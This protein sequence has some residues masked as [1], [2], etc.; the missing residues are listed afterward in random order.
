MQGHCHK[1]CNYD[2]INRLAFR[3]FSQLFIEISRVNVLYSFTTYMKR[4]FP[5]P[6]IQ[7]FNRGVL[8]LLHGTPSKLDVSARKPKHETI[9]WITNR[10]KL[11]M[12]CG[13]LALRPISHITQKTLSFLHSTKEEQKTKTMVTFE[14]CA[15]FLYCI[16]RDLADP[17]RWNGGMTE[18][19]NGMAE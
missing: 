19:R 10:A 5:F 1:N 11:W 9:S 17:L 3:I 18:W 2:Y 16:R 12:I 7:C 8:Q 14:T 15:I 6:V 13:L 4:F